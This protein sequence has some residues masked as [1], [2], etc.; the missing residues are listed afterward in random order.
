[1]LLHRNNCHMQRASLQVPNLPKKN[2]ETAKKCVWRRHHREH[3][4][5]A[6]FLTTRR[7]YLQARRTVRKNKK[8]KSPPCY[9]ELTRKKG[10]DTAVVGQRGRRDLL[11]IYAQQTNLLADKFILK[12]VKVIGPRILSEGRG[13]TNCRPWMSWLLRPLSGGIPQHIPTHV[14]DGL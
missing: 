12:L 5:S 8:L 1:M 4:K 10:L 2:C 13:D 6:E 14:S 9:F 7:N 11:R 3:L